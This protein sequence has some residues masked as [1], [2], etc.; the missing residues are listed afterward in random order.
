MINIYIFGHLKMKFD[1]NARMSENTII[2]LP[3]IKNESFYELLD[4]LKLEEDEI[5]ECFVNSKVVDGQK[6]MPVPNGARVAI[7]SSGMF[8]LC[9]GQHLKGHGYVTKSPPVKEVNYY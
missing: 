1:P 5:G 4:R 2:N 3:A 7:F 9:G 6:L 8:L